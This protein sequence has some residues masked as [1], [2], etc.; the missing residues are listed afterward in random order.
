[1]HTPTVSGAAQSDVVDDSTYERTPTNGGVAKKAHSH[2]HMHNEGLK[3]ATRD[4][5]STL[6]TTEEARNV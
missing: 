5:P 2:T 3:E 1:T 4:I 6:E